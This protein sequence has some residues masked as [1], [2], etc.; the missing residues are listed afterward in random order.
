MFNFLMNTV[1]DPTA[2]PS[3]K[4]APSFLR[5][6][7]SFV[8]LI[9]AL[10]LVVWLLRKLSH[11]RFGFF[12][13]QSSIKVLETKPLSQK[14]V[15]YIIEYNGQKMMVAESSQHLKIKDV[16]DKSK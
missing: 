3:I 6:G 14:S 7:I 13:H 12:N 8:V 11:S 1:T 2:A 15:L 9:L 16:E 10:W 5:L 4:T